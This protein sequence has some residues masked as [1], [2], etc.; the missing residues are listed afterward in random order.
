MLAGESST[1]AVDIL[2]KGI[3]KHTFSKSQEP[4]MEIAREIYKELAFRELLISCSKGYPGRASITPKLR[5]VWF[6]ITQRCNLRCK[7]CL[8]DASE[9]TENPLS[10]SEVEAIL[11]EAK[12]LGAK[13]FYVTVGEPYLLPNIREVFELIM[14]HGHLIVLT[15]ATLI[16]EDT[17][18]PPPKNSLFQVSLD[19]TEEINDLLRGKG[20]FKK[21]LKGIRILMERGH[22]PVVATVVTK[23]NLEN[24]PELTSF[25]GDIGISHHHL[26]FLHLKGRAL[27]KEFEPDPSEIFPFIDKAI[28]IGKEKEVIVDNYEAFSSRLVEPQGMKK[29]LCHAGVEMIT[30]GPEGELYPCPSMVGEE[31]FVFGN[32]RQKNLKELWE[33]NPHLEKIR[34]ISVASCKKCAS[35]AFRF[36][37]GGGCLAFKHQY[38]GDYSSEDP[39][40]DVYKHLILKRL[41]EMKGE[42]IYFSR[43]N[44]PVGKES[45]AVYNCA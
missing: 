21:A 12:A 2:I 1:P 19:G 18:V 17:Y 39:Y 29:D 25:L 42:Y 5:E 4:E 20:S 3:D 38:G 11:R 37:C 28:E 9:E 30:I 24:I 13:R 41:R 44:F 22:R 8:V 6:H 15:N 34:R 10:L 7:Y 40:C 14:D 36:Y 31:E 43:L 23:I 33:N 27:N 32:V 16:S 26:L 35:C 45:V